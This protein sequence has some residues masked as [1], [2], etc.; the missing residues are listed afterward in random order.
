M[1]LIERGFQN[2]TK[3]NYTFYIQTDKMGVLRNFL[4][5]NIQ[6]HQAKQKS[7]QI[8]ENPYRKAKQKDL[9][10][11]SKKYIPKTRKRWF[12]RKLIALR[13]KK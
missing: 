13:S 12:E 1:C 5:K 2:F 4:L 7:S 6:T 8:K 10:K 3:K 11:K 9:R